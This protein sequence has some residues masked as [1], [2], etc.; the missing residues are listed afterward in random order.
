MAKYNDLT[1]NL[2][3]PVAF[4][5]ATVPP[6]SAHKLAV[7]AVSNGNGGQPT[8]AMSDGTNWKVISIGATI[9]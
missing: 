4:T 9:S 6:A 2:L 3:Q 7:I 8:L 1:V 5:L